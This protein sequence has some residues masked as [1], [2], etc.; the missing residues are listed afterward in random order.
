MRFVSCKSKKFE[1]KNINYKQIS[2][3]TFTKYYINTTIVNENYVKKKD[4]NILKY[5][6]I[7]N[8]I[9]QTP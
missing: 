7:N 4:T 9:I 3:I 8:I 2:E 1:K 5:Y 6:I